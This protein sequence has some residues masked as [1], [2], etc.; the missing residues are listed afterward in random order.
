MS[1][2]DEKIL[3]SSSFSQYSEHNNDANESD[4]EHFSEEDFD[5]EDSDC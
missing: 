2:W 4:H 5:R 3:H 1:I